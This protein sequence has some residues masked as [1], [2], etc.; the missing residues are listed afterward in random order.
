VD[1]LTVE[2]FHSR[3]E[4][5]WGKP[6]AGFFGG[7]FEKASL[8][9]TERRRATCREKVR[10]G[11]SEKPWH[12]VSGSTCDIRG[13]KNFRETRVDARAVWKKKGRN[14]ARCGGKTVDSE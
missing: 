7:S 2:S 11:G 6:S 10:G 14:A 5:D 9:G 4:R 13:T 1:L 12:E 3:F 8:S